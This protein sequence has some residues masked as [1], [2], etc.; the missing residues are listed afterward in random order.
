[1]RH[2]LG[3]VAVAALIWLVGFLAARFAVQAVYVD[4]TDGPFDA[5]ARNEFRR[6]GFEPSAC[7]F[8]EAW[9]RVRTR[10]DRATL[11]LPTVLLLAVGLGAL[12]A[13]SARPTRP[14]PDPSLD[15]DG[16]ILLPRLLP[17]D[18]AT[19]VMVVP[20]LVGPAAA[21]RYGWDIV[22]LLDAG[23]TTSWLPNRFIALMVLGLS[24]LGAVVLGHHLGRGDRSRRTATPIDDLD[25]PD[26]RPVT[27]PGRHQRSLLGR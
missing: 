12:T 8:G 1:M 17:V 15:G 19:V 7:Y 11:I 5:A 18:L 2:L 21:I 27:G 6:A 14:G 20:L 3:L 9:E 26:A 13:S 10:L 16:P 23:C 4:L 25:E 24:I 22:A